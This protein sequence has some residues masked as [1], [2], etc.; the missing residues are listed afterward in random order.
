MGWGL[1][2]TY[3][4]NKTNSQ[5]VER[6]TTGQR[7]AYRPH[8]RLLSTDRLQASSST[9]RYLDGSRRRGASRGRRDQFESS[10]LEGSL[11]CIKVQAQ[12]VNERPRR[13]PRVASTQGT[14][15][16][17]LDQPSRGTSRCR[18]TTGWSRHSRCMDALM[19]GIAFWTNTGSRLRTSSSHTRCILL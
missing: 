10:V 16:K 7:V 1:A 9:S 17:G 2:F 19:R 5:I 4:G 11:R 14:D 6:S 8:R 18:Q 12:G 15:T 3:H 13:P